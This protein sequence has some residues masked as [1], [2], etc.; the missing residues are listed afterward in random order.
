MNKKILILC[1]TIIAS[2]TASA[3]NG[4][5]RQITATTFDQS[6][7][8]ENWLVN[9]E[10]VS[11]VKLLDN[12]SPSDSLRGVVIASPSRHDPD[13]YYHWVRDGALVMNSVVQELE[14]SNYFNPEEINELMFDYLTWVRTIQPKNGPGGLGEAKYFVDGRPYDLPWGRPQNDGPALRA[15]TLMN[16]AS[17]LWKAGH[18]DFV[19]KNLYKA[20]LPAISP[21]K[22]D[23]EYV[24]HHWQ[25]PCFDLWEETM[26]DHFYTRMAQLRAL[27]QGALL[28]RAANDI[29]AAEWYSQQA[30]QISWALGQHFNSS[31]GYIVT[32]LNTSR[33]GLDVATVL[34]LL[35]TY[36]P[37]D[38]LLSFSNEWVLATVANVERA[39]ERVYT[40][41]QKGYP[42]IAI[43]RYPEDVY[44]GGNPWFLATNAFAEYYYRLRAELSQLST[45][46][47]TDKNIDFFE[48]LIQD[49]PLKIHQQ[50]PVD[51]NLL[52]KISS[53]GD[54][55]L[56][57]T[58]FHIGP[59]SNSMMEQYQRDH[60]YQLSAKDLTWSYASFI[61]AMKARAEIKR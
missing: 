25:E 33:S 7:D 13:Y 55:F 40:L 17:I 37:N 51:G 41:N 26:G 3:N 6:E 49:H 20:E 44:Y 36:D 57:R 56:K 1:V 9:Q 38:P 43:G 12:V 16:W 21:I 48:R 31:A 14:A 30:E 32:T 46:T 60:G 22:K 59:N 47:I 5:K 19:L 58:R 24:S 2:I 39:F 23:L 45:I 4:I 8:F 61:T 28:A 27:R 53:K 18:K 54:E 52:N 29:S 15:V 42:A 11:W 10:Y 50:L 35:H 34:A